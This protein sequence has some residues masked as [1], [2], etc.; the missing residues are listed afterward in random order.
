MLTSLGPFER[1]EYGAAPL[2]LL[3]IAS[4]P[5]SGS[6]LLDL[7]LGA[8]SRI[9]SLGEIS[10][11]ERYAAAPV[12]AAPLG[13]RQQCTCGAMNIWQC[14]FWSNVD[15][16][17][18]EQAD[19]GLRDLDVASPNSAEFSLSNTLLFEAISRITNKKVIVDSSK[20]IRRLQMLMQIETLEVLP[21]FLYRQPHGQ[22][23]SMIKKYG[24]PDRH[25]ADNI[26]KNN[27]FLNLIS[28][29]DHV[30]L[31]YDRLVASPKQEL[32]RL[33]DFIGLEFEPGQ[34]NWAGRIKHNISGNGMRFSDR[35]ELRQDESWRDILSPR[36]LARIDAA[37]VGLEARIAGDEYR[38]VGLENSGGWPSVRVEGP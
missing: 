26:Q 16:T 3:F 12:N 38:R 18:R 2:T 29:H 34:L 1:L 21:V 15:R 24:N 6:T 11:L 10:T 30:L 31:R 28:R 19:V 33:L 8:H 22:I 7:L 36:L 37:I 20:S 17:L 4:L 9:E 5:H 23:S 25:I 14:D 13:R 27:E 35:G 32:L